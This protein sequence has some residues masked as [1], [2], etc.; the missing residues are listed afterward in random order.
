MHGPHVVGVVTQAQAEQGGGELLDEGDGVDVTDH[1]AVGVVGAHVGDHVQ[2]AVTGQQL[3][4][5]QAR[6]I[7][8]TDLVQVAGLE[9]RQVRALAV[10]LG[11][12]QLQRAVER[13]GGAV[14]LG[15]EDP[16]AVGRA[17]DRCPVAR[18]GP[19]PGGVVPD[20]VEAPQAAQVPERFRVVVHGVDGPARQVQGALAGVGEPEARTDDLVAV[21]APSQVDVL[22]VLGDVPQ[23][24]GVGVLKRG[25][26]GRCDHAE[27]HFIR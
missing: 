3:E 16:G 8:V 19:A 17:L 18:V 4:P 25:E 14:R 15:S 11:P 13:G 9:H 20:Q 24:G 6:Q 1:A 27:L 23:D 22:V 26:H 12:Q 7:G 21:V 2:V 10:L 5:D